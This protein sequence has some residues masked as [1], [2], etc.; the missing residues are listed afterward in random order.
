MKT[1]DD[2]IK[3]ST[4]KVRIRVLAGLLLGLIIYVSFSFYMIHTKKHQT[5]SYIKNYLENNTFLAIEEVHFLNS[6]KNT[7]QNFTYSIDNKNDSLCGPSNCYRLNFVPLYLDYFFIVFIFLVLIYSINILFNFLNKNTYKLVYKEVQLLKDLL[8]SNDFSLATHHSTVEINNI[9]EILKQRDQSIKLLYNAKELAH[10]MQ[11]P[12]TALEVYLS[13]KP[14]ELIKLV[15]QSL[16]TMN[17]K[18]LKADQ[19]YNFQEINLN[20]YIPSVIQKV[21]ITYPDITISQNFETIFIIQ[22]DPLEWERALFN[23]CKNSYEA[24]KQDCKLKIEITEKSGKKYLDIKDNGPGFPKLII[25]NFGK[26]SLSIGKEE[27]SGLGL[28]HLYNTASDSNL[29][30]NIFTDGG[31]RIKVTH[32]S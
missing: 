30:I 17:K 19:Y 8:K 2:L 20:E 4:N 1:L 22:G 26:S 15:H 28:M 3:I 18:I 29:D 21:L 25:D 11:S 32:R 14:D 16:K 7:N 12:I 6:F 10:D 24:V 9:I 27:G 31:A 23:V 5:T 13:D